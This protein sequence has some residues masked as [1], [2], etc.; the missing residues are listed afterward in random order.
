MRACKLAVSV[1]IRVVANAGLSLD[2]TAV[3]CACLVHVRLP[4]PCSCDRPACKLY[5]IVLAAQSLKP[6][7][8][9]LIRHRFEF[10]S[11]MAETCSQEVP[12]GQPTQFDDEATTC[13]AAFSHDLANKESVINL[14]ATMASQAKEALV[15]CAEEEGKSMSKD[16]AAMQSFIE[17]SDLRSSA[18]QK[19]ARS[20]SGG[21]SPEYKQC[22]NNKEKALFRKRWAEAELESL[23]RHRTK[24]QKF[25]RVNTDHGR[26][27]SLTQIVV[28]EGGLDSPD[29]IKAATNYVNKCIAMRGVW[30]LYNNMC[31]VMKYLYFETSVQET[32]TEAWGLYTK[33]KD[34]EEDNVAIATDAATETQVVR[35][36]GVAGA[37]PKAKAKAKAKTTTTTT[38]PDARKR[39]SSGTPQNPNN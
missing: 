31:E 36:A 17:K 6:K 34:Q 30:L 23:Q 16:A 2:A 7:L 18:G 33:W 4:G 3:T 20:S 14:E 32:F 15:S 28:A 10:L 29:A 19:F 21:K 35:G 22:A 9:I 38:T 39:G 25:Q 12:L 8:R 5:V 26:Y 24:E 1:V 13:G 27:L 37:Q 11:K